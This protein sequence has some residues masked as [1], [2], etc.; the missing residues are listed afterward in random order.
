M[1]LINWQQCLI[2]LS[3]CSKNHDAEKNIL[4]SRVI[5]GA[6]LKRTSSILKTA[7]YRSFSNKKKWRC[8]N[9]VPLYSKLYSK[10]VN[11]LNAKSSFADASSTE[12]VADSVLMIIWA[13]FK[14]WLDFGQLISEKVRIQTSALAFGHCGVAVL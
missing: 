13:E 11:V 12:M 1:R 6:V 4:F 9:L 10:N 7:N 14:S 5:C 2:K 3:T 8:K